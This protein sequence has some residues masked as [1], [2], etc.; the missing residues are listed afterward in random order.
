MHVDMEAGLPPR[1]HR[2]QEGPEPV[3]VDVAWTKA[4]IVTAIR[5]FD[6][7]GMRASLKVFRMEGEIHAPAM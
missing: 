1:P 3:V 7:I 6:G 2:V 4:A 5:N